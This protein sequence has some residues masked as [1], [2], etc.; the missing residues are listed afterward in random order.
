MKI[1]RFLV[2]NIKM[3]S[4]KD[5][6]LQISEEEYRKDHALSYSTIAKYER[7]GFSNLSKLFDKVES[8]SLTFGSVVDTLIT[9]TEEDFN[10]LFIVT[11]IDNPLSDTL[12]IITKRLFTVFKD[13]YNKLTDIPN[14][15]LLDAIEDIQWN[16]HWLPV[17]RVKKIKED[18]AGYYSLLYIAN[19]RSIISSVVY[20][21]ALKTVDKLKSADS[22]RYYFEPNNVFDN[23]IERLYQL[24]FKSTFN[25]IEYRC[26]ADEIICLHKQKILIPVDLKTSSKPEWEFYKSFLDWSYSIQSRLYWRI[27]RDNMNKDPYFKD[28]ELANY[29]FIVI[30]RK[31]LTPLVWEFENTKTEG[32]INLNNGTILRDPFTIG[33]ELYHYLND[34]PTVPD[35]IHINKPNKIEEWI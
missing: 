17:T 13:T 18:C 7:E 2:L 12:I 20:N 22:T 4:L 1:W 26:M 14:G 25:N 11:Q 24:K 9:G 28:F 31:T 8:P 3:K 16:N 21:D 23:S 29:K 15:Y 5:I 35:N 19:G 33:E 6:S 30:N 10:N 27:I 32:D 34:K